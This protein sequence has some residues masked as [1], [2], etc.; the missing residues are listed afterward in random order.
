MGE[1]VSDFEDLRMEEEESVI[2]GKERV[3]NGR[4]LKL[5]KGEQGRGIVVVSGGKS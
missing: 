5:G 2:V 3:W 1:S 4:T